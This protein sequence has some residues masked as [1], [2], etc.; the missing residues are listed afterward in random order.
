MM[1][2]IL[3]VLIGVALL[4]SCG[5]NKAQTGALIGAGA[6]ALAGQAIG[7]ST[8]GT[9]IGL[10]AG[11]FLGYMIGN[12]MD[13]HDQAKLNSVYE[14]SPSYQQTN[15]VNPDSGNSYQVTPQPAYSNPNDGRVC[16][17]AEILTNIDGKA[18]KT[19]A[20]ACRD[21]NGRWVI[22]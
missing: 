9:L 11:G 1:K 5:M 2:R 13:K 16:R 18:E 10:A 12:E 3:I 15:W 17:E 14:T 21:A 7:Q 20:T 22:Q 8:E 4:C 19:Y 6:G